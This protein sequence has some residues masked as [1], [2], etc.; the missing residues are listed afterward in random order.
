MKNLFRKIIR[1][2]LFYFYYL[3]FKDKLNVSREGKPLIKGITAVISM[4]NESYT[5]PFCLESLVEIV[6]QIVIID[7]GSEDDSLQKARIFQEKNKNKLEINIIEMPGALLGDCREAGLKLSKYQWHLRWDADMVAHTDGPNNMLKLRAKILKDNTPRAIQLSRLNLYGDLKHTMGKVKD[8][9]EPFL[10]WLSKNVYYK[11]YGKFDTIRVPFYFKQIIEEENF[12]F[13]CT[14]LKSAENLIHRFNY[15]TW[16]DFYNRY[17]N[18]NRP[19]NISDY[20]KFKVVRNN[21]LFA[22]NETKS[23]KYRF[24]RQLVSQFKL[25]DTNKYGKYP[26]ILEEELHNNLQRFTIIYK[27]GKPFYRIDKEDV[28]MFDYIPLQR[29]LD[30]SIEDFFL[31]VNKEKIEMYS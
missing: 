9:G 14:S 13:H 11:E 24:I 2:I 17:D 28:E 29:D 5:L 4:K 30:W 1:P 12:I 15:F 23:L 7:N 10:I 18:N 21:Y 25:F 27:N 22:T 19:E 31:K 26:K 8:D 16:R 3:P 6:D 20:E